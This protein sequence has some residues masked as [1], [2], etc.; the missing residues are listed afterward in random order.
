MPTLTKTTDTKRAAVATKVKSTHDTKTVTSNKTVTPKPYTTSAANAAKFVALCGKDDSVRVAKA[1]QIGRELESGATNGGLTK[2]Y[3]D[4]LI[5]AGKPVPKSFAAAISQSA[6]A[7]A[8]RKLVVID[9]PVLTAA[10]RD[11]LLL[12]CLRLVNVRKAAVETL[13]SGSFLSP[14]NFDKAVSEV[15]KA[16]TAAKKNKTADDDTK[17]DDDDDN[18]EPTVENEN[19]SM[20]AD[21]KRAVSQIKSL[22]A[23]MAK[24][25]DPTESDAALEMLI[26]F[27]DDYALVPEMSI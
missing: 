5:A 11:A 22:L 10:D 17:N 27:A 14:A 9:V 25:P 20:L 18:D 8:R 21:V 24:N 16:D 15:I 1:N 3:A 13:L 23:L 6:I 26:Q 4:A 12:S 19:L 7:Y 2:T